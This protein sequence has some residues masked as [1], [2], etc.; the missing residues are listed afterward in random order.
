MSITTTRSGTRCALLRFLLVQDTL[1]PVADK[2]ALAS[3]ILGVDRQ[4]ASKELVNKRYKELVVLAH[5]DKVPTELKAKAN[6][7]TQKLND[8]KGKAL[9]YI[10]NKRCGSQFPA[11]FNSVFLPVLASMY[12]SLLVCQH[13]RTLCC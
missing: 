13:G 6:E 12:L 8:A 10:A 7:A 11:V 3:Q 1:D 2:R 9:A 5:P 4:G